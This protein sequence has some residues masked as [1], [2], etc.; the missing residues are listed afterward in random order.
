MPATMFHVFLLKDVSRLI[1][2]TNVIREIN[3]G[4]MI[5]IRTLVAHKPV[6]TVTTTITVLMI[7]AT[8]LLDVST[9]HMT[10]TIITPVLLK[11]VRQINAIMT[12]LIVMIAMLVQMIPVM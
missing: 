3:V 5:V 7:V 12:E 9:L 4:I 11:N 1:S 8:H 6:L 2:P 10:V